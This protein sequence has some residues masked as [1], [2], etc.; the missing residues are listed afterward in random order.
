MLLAQGSAGAAGSEVSDSGAVLH[1]SST[2]GTRRKKTRAVCGVCLQ[3]DTISDGWMQR[4]TS[5]DASVH[6]HC[7]SALGLACE[8][9][10]TKCGNCSF[11]KVA[12]A[13]SCLI[14]LRKLS[15]KTTCVSMPVTR[16][17][18]AD[19]SL[20]HAPCL[21]LSR[22]H[23]LA[24]APSLPFSSPAAIILHQTVEPSSSRCCVCRGE[25]GEMQQCMNATCGRFVHAS[26]AADLKLMWFATSRDYMAR[27]DG[28]SKIFAACSMKHVKPDQV[29][30]TCLRPYD[31]QGSTMVQCDDCRAWFHCDCLGIDDNEEDLN[32]LQSKQFRC[33]ECAAKVSQSAPLYA[34]IFMCDV[35]RHWSHAK[36][37][38][39][40]KSNAPSLDFEQPLSSQGAAVTAFAADAL[41][42]ILQTSRMAGNPDLRLPICIACLS[43]L[44]THDISH[45][46]IFSI[47]SRR[48]CNCCRSMHQSLLYLSVPAPAC[49]LCPQ[50]LLHPKA[51]SVLV[52]ISRALTSQ[53]SAD[54]TKQLQKQY[55][56]C[57]L[58]T[59]DLRHLTIFQVSNA[60][61]TRG[62][63]GSDLS[64]VFLRRLTISRRSRAFVG[65][66]PLFSCYCA[67][68]RRSSCYQPAIEGRPRATS[69]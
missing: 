4:C 28:P 7:A 63:V 23:R 57:R 37:I 29:F 53:A 10:W 32:D 8:G 1:V 9:T 48:L 56:S 25:E 43:P 26:C 19:V 41:L 46:S 64:F 6:F 27:G 68:R 33:S 69:T 39:P 21:L 15:S 17:D 60:R 38:Q 50:D 54:E 31:T 22:I 49:T 67:S 14:C 11:P 34:P 42:L 47:L 66:L 30:C 59:L 52:Q 45:N 35:R 3:E 62:C 58:A 13:S 65:Q 55:C 18:N 24:P 51:R 20:V 12:A 2:I 44:S 36:I 5:C 40:P 61:A 16:S